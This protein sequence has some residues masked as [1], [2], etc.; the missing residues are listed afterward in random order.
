M[1]L[2][3]SFMLF[4]EIVEPSESTIDT[5][6]LITIIAIS[7]LTIALIFLSTKKTI[8]DTRSLVFAAICIALSFSL[9]FIKFP[10]PFLNYG[11]SITLASFVPLLIYSYFYGPAKGLMAGIV[12]GLL[13]FIQ[14]PYY[15][16]PIQFIL[17]YILAFGAIAFAGVFKKTFKSEKAS[18]IT[19]AVVVGLARLCMHILAGIIFFNAGFV[20][21]EF[22]QDSAF[23]YSTVYN[24]I[25]IVPDLLIALGV[26]IYMLY[27]GYYKRIS[28]KLIT[29]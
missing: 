17:D 19:G 21:P 25:Y 5:V 7:L 16:T 6:K 24:L 15:L 20:Y 22:P 14:E 23:L 3:N 8:M 9:S 11:G 13:Q 1:K 28:E 2:F 4:S 18:V 12:Y 27:T 29:K 26:I 10:L